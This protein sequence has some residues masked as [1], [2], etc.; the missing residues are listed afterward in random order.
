MKK[1]KS[2]IKW[3]FEPNE[4]QSERKKLIW[5]SDCGA[6]EYICFPEE[7]AL[8]T[9]WERLNNYQLPIGWRKIEFGLQLHFLCPD[10]LEK[11]KKFG[12]QLLEGKK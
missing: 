6:M 8:D 5:C 11:R 12:Q 10:C 9:F 1:I 2:F 3:L 4:P 7:N